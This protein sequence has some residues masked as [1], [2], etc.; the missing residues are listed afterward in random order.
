VDSILEARGFVEAFE[1][2]SDFDIDVCEE[3]LKDIADIM[4]KTGECLSSSWG[5]V[6]ELTLRYFRG[7]PKPQGHR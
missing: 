5:Y 3:K 4:R 2:Y 1:E 7:G 6:W